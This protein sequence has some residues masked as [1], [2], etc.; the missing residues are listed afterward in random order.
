MAL[1][2]LLESAPT[3]GLLEGFGFSEVEVPVA[4][5][6][7]RTDRYEVRCFDD[8]ING[9]VEALELT[10]SDRGR[11]GILMAYGVSV[12]LG[13]ERYS[14]MGLLVVAGQRDCGRIRGRTF[15][16]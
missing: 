1:L 12:D 4:V 15:A 7:P 5:I 8:N 10:E 3:S 11:R 9:A 14:D 2:S 13:V 6:D 16:G